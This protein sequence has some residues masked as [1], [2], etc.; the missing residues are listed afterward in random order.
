[1]PRLRPHTERDAEVMRPLPANVC[2]L[3]QHAA[4]HRR[5]V[6]CRASCTAAFPTREPNVSCSVYYVSGLQDPSTN[7][8][9]GAKRDPVLSFGQLPIWW[10]IEVDSRRACASYGAM[11][12]LEGGKEN[13]REGGKS[14]CLVAAGRWTN[15]YSNNNI[16]G[17]IVPSDTSG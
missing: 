10:S 5:A 3:K 4:V 16:S 17:C 9:T 6:R 7:V 14:R 12:R 2:G 1:M 15:T 8:Q 11:R 13:G